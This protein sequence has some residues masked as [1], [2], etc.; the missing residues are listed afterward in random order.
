M[1]YYLLLL[2]FFVVL[3][4]SAQSFEGTLSEVRV[5]GRS[6]ASLPMQH[7][8]LKLDNNSTGSLRGKIPAIGKMPGYVEINVPIRLQGK[9]LLVQKKSSKA[10][11]FHFKVGG[12][13]GIN[14][15]EWKARVEDGV[16]HFYLSCHSKLAF[17]TMARVSMRFEGKI[18]K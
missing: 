14:L 10:G 8:V 11:R 2:S 1:R 13:M 4:L 16:L 3:L 9:E 6:Y 18:E 15:D 12:S 7:F 17:V 5:N